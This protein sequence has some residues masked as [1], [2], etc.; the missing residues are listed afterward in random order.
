MT[1][2]ARSHTMHFRFA[3]YTCNA[4]A[5]FFNTSGLTYIQFL[6]TLYNKFFLTCCFYL[7][8][9]PIDVAV[10]RSYGHVLVAD[11]G[12]SCVFVFDSDG[13]ILFQ[14]GKR[15]MFKLISSVTVGPAGEILVADSRIQ[16]FSAKGDFSEEIYAEGKGKGR[17]GGI[18]VDADGKIVASRSDKGRNI[19]QVLKLGG[20]AILTEIDSHSSKL[21]RPTGIA[22]LPNNHLVVVDLGNDCIKKYRYW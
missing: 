3:R 10:D 15:S 8:Q 18:A 4:H 17:Y 22:V 11:N 21:R 14:V 5:C 16:V 20:G 19:I 2:F 13:K 6:L 7:I 1:P 9:E 12:Q